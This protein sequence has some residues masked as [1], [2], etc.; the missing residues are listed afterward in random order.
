MSSQVDKA[1][2]SLR[3]GS[4]PEDT[5]GTLKSSAQ[6]KATRLFVT[7][8]QNGTDKDVLL[9]RFKAKYGENIDWIVVCN[10]DHADELG[11]HS[12][13][14]VRFKKQMK[15]SHSALDT[16]GG[17]HGDYR[18]IRGREENVVRYIL[19][20]GNYISEGF[21][22]SVEAWLESKDKKKNP[23]ENQIV[24][25][26]KSGADIESLL[27]SDHRGYVGYRMGA[28]KELISEI[29]LIGLKNAEL[30]YQLD[31]NL[32]PEMSDLPQS[33]ELYGDILFQ[34]KNKRLHRQRNIYIY[35]ETG[36]G[37]T[38]LLEQL[39]R[40]KRVYAMTSKQP[41]EGYQDGCF[42]CMVFEEFA[43]GSAQLTLMN[44]LSGGGATTDGSTRYHKTVK[45]DNLLVIVVSNY[46]PQEVYPNTVGNKA[47]DAFLTRWNF[48]K[49]T[50]S[51]P[52]RIWLDPED[53]LADIDEAPALPDWIVTKK[54][55][56]FYGDVPEY[57]PGPKS[58][59]EIHI[60]KRVNKLT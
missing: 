51:D 5:M 10:E 60:E 27:D 35:T 21:P 40:R 9:N 53:Q 28:T 22:S 16:I 17:K 55:G 59:W 58:A 45:T 4:N 18:V 48:Y 19:K 30:L 6:F 3:D 54:L 57:D 14:A 47:Y 11:V 8:P 26:I 42:D 37:K 25:L 38:V 7:F 12:H 23:K 20:D 44:N 43:P 49:F 39:K 24:D 33:V 31:E 41:L 2:P 56:G 50:Q 13:V 34:L 1:E 46:A 52:I 15:L 32:S 36:V 29:K